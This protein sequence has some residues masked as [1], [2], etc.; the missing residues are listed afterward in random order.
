[1]HMIAFGQKYVKK[2]SMADWSC[3]FV[4]NMER[5]GRF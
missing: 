1:M 5:S 2:I 3:T 4:S